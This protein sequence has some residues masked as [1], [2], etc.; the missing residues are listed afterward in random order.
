MP[1]VI[2]E[3]LQEIGRVEHLPEGTLQA[4]EQ[5]FAQ[6]ALRSARMHMAMNSY[7]GM[8]EA[9]DDLR[10]IGRPKKKTEPGA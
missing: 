8:R 1:N 2:V 4:P 3:L 7:E 5:Q 6:N 9:L 10:E